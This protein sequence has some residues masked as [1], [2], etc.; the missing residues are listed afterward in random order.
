M[1]IKLDIVDTVQSIIFLVAGGF[2]PKPAIRRRF[3]G[4]AAG[5]AQNP[6]KQSQLL[7]SLEQ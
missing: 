4:R 1:G 7:I 3:F 6:L 2:A 5:S